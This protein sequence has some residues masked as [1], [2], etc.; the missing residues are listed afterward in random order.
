MFLQT[1]ASELNEQITDWLLQ[2]DDKFGVCKTGSS[3]N[4]GYN[5][6]YTSELYNNC[7]CGITR[8]IQE[9]FHLLINV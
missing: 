6:P 9:K 8:G 3:T 1:N 7:L 4:T 5:T 2:P